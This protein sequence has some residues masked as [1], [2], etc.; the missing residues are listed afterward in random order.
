MF[1]KAEMDALTTACTIE[2]LTS[3]AETEVPSSSVTTVSVLWNRI[4]EVTVD[5]S[6]AT[7]W[8]VRRL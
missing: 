4:D 7:Y 2:A 5:V 1:P 6:I 3:S 8:S